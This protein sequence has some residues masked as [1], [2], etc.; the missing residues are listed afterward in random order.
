MSHKLHRI[1]RLVPCVAVVHVFLMA[2]FFLALPVFAA[3][4][5]RTYPID[6]PEVRTL[7]DGTAVVEIDGAMQD[8]SVVGAPIVPMLTSRLY[9][10]AGEAV[11]RVEVSF[12]PLRTLPGTYVLAHGTTPRPTSDPSPP[13]PEMADSAIYSSDTPYPRTTWRQ[14]SEQTLHGYRIVLTDLYPVRYLPAS[15]IVQYAESV[16]VTIYA[17][18]SKTLDHGRLAPRTGSQDKR[19]VMDLID[20]GETLEA[21][22]EK[23]SAAPTATD[24]QYLLITTAALQSAFTPLLAHR[25]SSAGGG[26]TTHSTTVETI[27]ASQTGRDLAEKIRNYIKANYASHGTRFVVLGGDADGPQAGQAVP[28]RGCPGASGTYSD[29]YIPTDYY[30]ACLDGTWDG[31][32]NGVFG[33]STDGAGGGDIDWLA[34]VAVGRIPA[35]TTDEAQNAI[36]KIIAY[37]TGNNPFRALLVGEYLDNTPTWGGDKMD[38]VYEAMT[39]MPRDTLYDRDMTP[40]VWTASTLQTMLSGNAYNM[41]FHLGHSGPHN[42]MR[43]VNSSLDSI[44]NQQYFL[45]YTQGC[46]SGA[47]DTGSGSEDSIGEDFLVRNMSNAFAFIGNSRYGWYNYGAVVNNTG[48]LVHRKFTEAIFQSGIRRLGLANNRSKM[49]LDYALGYFRW[50]AMAINLMGDPATPLDLTTPATD[51]LV[52]IPSLSDGFSVEH[53]Q[54]VPLAAWVTTGHGVPLVGAGVTA[55]FSTGEAAVVL[56]DDGRHNDGAAGDGLYGGVWTPR[57]VA[58]TVTVTVTATKSG[59]TTGR[60]SV[61]GSVAQLNE[62]FVSALSGSGVGVPDTTLTTDA[63]DAYFSVPIGFPFTFYGEKFTMAYISTNGTISF[64]DPGS[65]PSNAKIPN[66]AAPNYLIA[67]FWDDLKVDPAVGGRI[68]YATMGREGERTF[69]VTWDNMLHK[70]ETDTNNKIYFQVQLDEMSGEIRMGY[71][72]SDGQLSQGVS[73]TIGIEKK[74]IGLQYSYNKAPFTSRQA[75]LAFRPRPKKVVPMASTELLL[76][77]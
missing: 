65:F 32:G 71:Y 68:S 39:A 18:P 16:T 54:E 34:E 56:Y 58:S 24:R 26:F 75:G 38:Y 48:N 63:D 13:P 31:N 2:A 21:E 69:Y 46:H 64:T 23:T 50:L 41:I 15:G 66:P 55:T 3:S 20:N 17:S 35:D 74:D 42:S 53:T 8:T 5:S 14:G 51:I 1:C 29:S 70:D 37:E 36:A 11:D 47:F 52:G 7:P 67:P 6:K 60:S 12:G 28:T 40:N 59:F 10:P 73:A 25:A 72:L 49:T 33:E 45:V 62:Y 27:A 19:S 9:V 30:Y 76:L 44:T 43:L 22:G 61:H 57:T 4:Y 77:Q